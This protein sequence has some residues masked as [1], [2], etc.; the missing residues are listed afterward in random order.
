[1]E[2]WTAQYDL[3]SPLIYSIIYK[4]S[5]NVSISENILQKTF[6]V[7][8]KELTNSARSGVVCRN[9]LRN[10]YTLTLD[11]LSS[12]G[13]KPITIKPLGEKIPLVNLLYF[14][15][16]SLKEAEERLH[17]SMQEVLLKLRYEFTIFRNQNNEALPVLRTLNL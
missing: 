15:L 12:S 3:Y 9:L 5:G 6:Q 1:M 2:V 17:M 16:D 8:N 14:E 4:M 13:L 10:A 7:S 11:Y